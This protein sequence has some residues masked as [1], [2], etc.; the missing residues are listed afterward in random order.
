MKFSFVDRIGAHS[1]WGVIKP[2][3]KKLIDQGHDVDYVF[4]DDGNTRDGLQ[5]P[6]GVNTINITVPSS[7]RVMRTLVQQAVFAKEYLGYLRAHQ[8]DVVHT[9][10]A[11]PSIVARWAAARE[12]VPC[13]VSTQHELYGSMHPHYRWGLKLTERYCSAIVYVSRTVARSF[14]HE[15]KMVEDADFGRV[16]AHV[17]IPNGIDLDKIRTATA[18]VRERIPGKIICAGRMVPVKGQDVLVRALPPVVHAHP[19]VRLKLIGSGPMEAELRSLV[20]SLGL[21]NHVE[22]AG[23]MPHD[24]V[25][26]EMASA[27]LVVVP[28]KQEGYGLV[29][30]EALA[31]G[32]PL[33]VSDIPVFRE[34]LEGASVQAGRFPVG[35]EQALTERLFSHFVHASSPAGDAGTV[36]N[37]DWS[38]FSSDA[39]AELY[40]AV[41]RTLPC[42][43][44]P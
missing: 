4:M 19:H 27:S 35:R 36:N 7:N 22:F 12:G 34:V 43:L 28:S 44:G 3:A 41:Y 37:E 2:T 21:E 30:A 40:L 6:E 33:L 20:T 18:D 15:A 42:R 16:P 25:L 24:A 32:A 11:V 9:N 1:I 29:V 14:G 38:R 31:C 26:R 5:L 8:P 10:F 13:I 17:V 23:W 39:M